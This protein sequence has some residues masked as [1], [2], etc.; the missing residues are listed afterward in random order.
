MIYFAGKMDEFY[1][2]LGDRGLL[3]GLFVAGFFLHFMFSLRMNLPSVYPE[4]F[5]VAAKSAY[6]SGFGSAGWDSSVGWLTAALYTPFYYLINEPVIRYRSMLVLNG[7]IAALIPLLTYKITAGLGLEKAW[8]RTLCAIVS[9]AG[10]GAF[11]YSKFTWSETL[12]VFFPFVL[13]WLFIKAAGVKF[14][15]L[16]VLLSLFAALVCAL[17]P[18]A[19]SRLWGLVVIYILTVILSKYILKVKSFSVAVFLPSFAACTLAQVY[20]GQRLTGGTLLSAAPQN[21]EIGTYLSA[22][23]GR[24]YYFAASTWGLAVIGAYL[25]VTVLSEAFR[26]ARS[27]NKKTE[28]LPQSLFFAAFALFTLTFNLITLFIPPPAH[29]AGQQAYIFGRYI[30]SSV[31]LML[32]FVLCYVFMHGLDLKK[33]LHSA[34]I[35]V[36]VFMLFFAFTVPV[37]TDADLLGTHSIQGLSP[38]RLGQAQGAPFTQENLFFTVS[39]VFCFMALFVVFIC[40]AER[41]RRHMISLCAGLVLIYSCLHSALV[42]LPFEAERAQREYA[43]AYAVSERIYN[44]SAA[45]PTYVLGIDDEF[46]SVL[47]FL[48]RNAVIYTAD[49]ADELPEDCFVITLG[50]DGQAAFAVMGEKAEAYVISQK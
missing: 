42:Y 20:A 50:G 30:D 16:R 43:G 13:V 47:R 48:N 6:F 2:R 3:L 11:A 17:L 29:E 5:A 8:Q 7:F 34:I 10:A 12:C 26:S 40:N 23:L 49:S 38:L 41:Y 22:L 25:C 31:P 14:P 18:A 39:A 27:K 32:V 19:D 36:A 24:F 44:S 33:L 21:A 1:R 45:P 4:E 37:M 46:T 9:G 15:V 35:S 28:N